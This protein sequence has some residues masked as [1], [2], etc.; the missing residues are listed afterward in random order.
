MSRI[1]KKIIP[2]PPPT[3]VTF[4]DSGE[5][6]VAGP[7]GTLSRVFRSDIRFTQEEE[8]I[9]SAPL[10]ETG[11]LRALWGTYMAHLS[12]MITG[13]TEKFQKKLIVDGV[14]FRAEGGGDTLTLNVGFSHPVILKVPEGLTLE[15][16]KNVITIS[17]IDKEQVGQ[18]AAV[19]RSKKKPEP[20]KGKGIHYDTEVVRRKQGKKSS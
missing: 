1:G 8:G 18:F 20:Y 13:V 2:V 5:V 7:Y 14:G 19:V 11:E 6:T 16:V 3:T 17:G 15:V 4:S 10:N 12:N 9:T